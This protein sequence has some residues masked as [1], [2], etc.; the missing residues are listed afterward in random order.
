LEIPWELLGTVPT[1]PVE[2]VAYGR[3]MRN[4]W[5]AVGL[6]GALMLVVALEARCEE[7]GSSVSIGAARIAADGKVYSGL[8]LQ[9]ANMEKENPVNIWDASVVARGS[10][11]GGAIA[12][13]AGRRLTYPEPRRIR[14]FV[15]LMMGAIVVPPIPIP[16]VASGI[17]LEVNAGVVHLRA[18][19]AA[20]A[21]PFYLE[22]VIPRYTVSLVFSPKPQGKARH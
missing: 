7:D 8:H 12:L 10:G 9:L 19:A 17:G 2:T 16:L 14:P 11:S 3:G 4:K 20:F 15:D 6:V 1:V 22:T 18:E 21:T 5:W 13:M